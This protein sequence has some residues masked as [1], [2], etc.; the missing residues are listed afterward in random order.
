MASHG[1]VPRGAVESSGSM[2][3]ALC[4]LYT[5]CILVVG[6]KSKVITRFQVRTLVKAEHLEAAALL[7]RVFLSSETSAESIGRE[8]EGRLKWGFKMFAAFELEE[9]KVPRLVGF[10]EVLP[11]RTEGTKSIVQS[12]CVDESYRRLG[13]AT[14]LVEA[15]VEE[16][17]RC[18]DRVYVNVE[19]FNTEAK[20]FY[21]KLGFYTLP[22]SSAFG[23]EMMV[24]SLHESNR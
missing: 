10:A 21:S 16:A 17:F 7:S 14:R 24:R 18:T 4:I 15:C 9:N 13:L 20:K 6:C 11:T 2:S 3:L 12:V 5:F 1:L 19:D 8:L 22:D 23:S